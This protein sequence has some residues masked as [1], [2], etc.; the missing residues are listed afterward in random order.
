MA[1]QD[2]TVTL[3]PLGNSE[4]YRVVT[5]SPTNGQA[6]ADFVSPFGEERINTWQAG[7]NPDEMR[8][9]GALLYRRLFSS[10]IGEAFHAAQRVAARQGLALRLKLT[11][12]GA[13]TQLPWEYLYDPDTKQFLCLDGGLALTR[14]FP[15]TRTHT[16][17]RL[18]LETGLCF[19]AR[20]DAAYQLDAVNSALD[21]CALPLDTT[22]LESATSHAIPIQ[23]LHLRSEYGRDPAGGEFALRASDAWRDHWLDALDLMRWFDA[24][25]AVQLVVIDQAADAETTARAGSAFAA[26]LVT[27]QFVPA[28]LA[29]QYPLK[30]ELRDAF[31]KTFYR[32]LTQDAGLGL[33]VTEGRRTLAAMDGAW[34]WGAPV[35]FSA[36]GDDQPNPLSEIFATNQT[37]VQLVALSDQA[38][39]QVMNPQR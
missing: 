35:L 38:K 27:R 9:I 30:S 12:P 28:A 29:F 18:T 11:A 10:E 3:A 31:F 7:L 19:Y 23:A 21:L 15:S 34:E 24:N 37:S 6:V 14:Y 33:A 25:P 8:M 16:Q 36:L 39:T 13:L 32:A 4:R 17:T 20:S 22:A 5:H 26:E 2:F 1:Y